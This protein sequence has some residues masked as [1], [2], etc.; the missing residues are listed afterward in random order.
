M[1]RVNFNRNC[2]AF[3]N[4]AVLGVVPEDATLWKPLSEWLDD[5]KGQVLARWAKDDT[6]P[7]GG[8][9]PWLVVRDI[10]STHIPHGDAEPRDP[11]EHRLLYHWVKSLYDDR[12]EGRNSLE[13]ENGRIKLGR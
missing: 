7:D 5:Y 1:E 11:W 8:V 3:V 13:V 2:M 12:S 4:H 10:I 9:D 6:S